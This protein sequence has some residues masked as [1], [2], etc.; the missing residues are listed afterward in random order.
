M[1]WAKSIAI[2]GSTIDEQTLYDLTDK[3]NNML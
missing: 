1:L 2:E 3:S